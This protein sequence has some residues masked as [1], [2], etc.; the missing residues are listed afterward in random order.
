L[1]TSPLAPS[2]P[3]RWPAIE[4]P[5][6]IIWSQALGAHKLEKPIPEHIE[7]L[8]SDLLGSGRAPAAVH[9]VHRT[10]RAAFNEAVRRSRITSNP[11]HI[12]KS[13][14]LVESEIE[15][16]TM[17]EAR[18]ILDTAAGRRNG[19][20]WAVA[21]SL[22]LRQG[23]VL[24]Q[25]WGDVDLDVGTL[26]V[27]RALQRHVWQHGCGGACGRKRGADCPDRK[28]GGLVVS[29]PSLAPAAG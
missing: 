15:P 11:A 23:E 13:P 9:Q 17:D 12:A 5:S 19:A 10:L 24:G 8:Y 2:G 29:R 3:R 20:R 22:R 26:I 28:D 6:T 27:R 21:Q 16:F 25:R 1:R 7:R 18:R 14:R 4:R